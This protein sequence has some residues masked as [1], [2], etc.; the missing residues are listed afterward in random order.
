M[1]RTSPFAVLSVLAAVACLALVAPAQTMP[2]AEIVDVPAI[3][4]GLCVSNVFQSN[5]VLQRD[6]PI[7]A[8]PGR[9]AP[10]SLCC[11]YP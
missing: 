2:H 1:R 10:M 9:M 3:Q 7:A 5:M 6:K 8:R 11:H 4:N